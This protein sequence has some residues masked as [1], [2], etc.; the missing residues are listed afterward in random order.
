MIIDSLCVCVCVC[1][2]LWQV[3][4]EI[5]RQKLEGDD[6]DDDDFLSLFNMPSSL[7]PPSCTHV[8]TYA[9][10]LIIRL[11][12]KKKEEAEPSEKE[13]KKKN[14]IMT[15]Q[16]NGVSGEK[17]TNERP[18]SV[19]IYK[20]VCVRGLIFSSTLLHA[21]D[22]HSFMPRYVERMIFLLFLSPPI[23]NNKW[24]GE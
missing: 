17:W 16:P 21:Y 12:E 9:T 14:L 13:A 3:R 15:A 7:S 2:K 23:L 6:T 4:K 22:T 5:K 24:R 1:K 20:R 19:C 10:H 18:T 8:Q 11:Q